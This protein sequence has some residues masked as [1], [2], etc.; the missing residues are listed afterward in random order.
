MI[1]ND[2]EF[3]LW[4]AK[5]LVH[6]YKENPDIIN[7]VENIIYKYGLEKKTY[8]D[9]FTEIHTN[10]EQTI[11][12]LNKTNRLFLDKFNTAKENLQQI[13]IIEKNSIFE[14]IDLN[15]LFK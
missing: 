11:S 1:Q 13:E 3:L 8:Q 12:D 15:K 9:I 14:N 7:V 6:K 4:I 5:R 10:I 2:S